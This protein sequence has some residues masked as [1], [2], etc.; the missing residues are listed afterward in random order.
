MPRSRTHTRENIL[1]TAVALIQERGYNAFSYQHVSA[2]LG[3]RNA[4]VHYHFPSKG[5]LGL[6]VVERYH[7]LFDEW[8]AENTGSGTD[9]LAMLRGYFAI[10]IRF[11]RDG[12]KVCPLGVLEAEYKAIPDPMREAV[13][14]LDADI[15]SFLAQ[16]L[17]Q[18]RRQGVF[19][20]EGAPED[21]ALVIV[22]ALQG[23][24]QIARAAGIKTVSRVI[25]QIER[26]LGMDR[27]R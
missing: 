26:D 22:A 15:R 10:P 20:F 13:R 7:R 23:A 25:R 19:R 9:P 27:R 12:G 1:D 5:D 3:I 2:D 4:A 24:L 6:A 18:G 8:V 21:K 14:E 11:A 16:V 17:E